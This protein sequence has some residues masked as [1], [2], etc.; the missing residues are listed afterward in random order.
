MSAINLKVIEGLEMEGRINASDEE[1]IRNVEYAIRRGHPQVKSQENQYDRIA[2]VGSGPSLAKTE[3]ELVKLVHEGAKLVTMNGAYHWCLEHNLKPSAQIVLDAR[4]SNARFVEPA[5]PG[6]TYIL[7]S[8]CHPKVWDAVEGREKVWI[9]HA[10]NEGNNLAGL[11]GDFYLG[12][13]QGAPGGT[14]VATRA[15]V[16][17]RMLGYLRFDLFGV[18]SCVMDG[19][20]HAM[21]QPENAHDKFYQLKVGPTSNPEISRTFTVTGWHCKQFEDILQFIRVNGE[22]VLV[23][24]HGDGLIAYALQCGSD[25][26][27]DEV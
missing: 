11:L 27:M 24:V 17:L 6:C 25:L 3:K 13:W 1:L 7:A 4:E 21:P 10:I 22:Y 16:V 23:N 2:L 14:T 20:H 9:F 26:A 15:M 8:Q 19:V 5:V 18:D 12:K